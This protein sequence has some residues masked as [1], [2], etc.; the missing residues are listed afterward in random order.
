MKRSTDR[1]LTTH[2]SS[3]PRPDDLVELLQARNEDPSKDAAFRRRAAE[4]IGEVVDKQVEAGIDV[5]SDGEMGKP[6][7]VHYIRDR[8]SGFE[9]VNTQPSQ[10]DFDA[11]F[12]GYGKSLSEGAALATNQLW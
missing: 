2:T 8:V 11:E 4:A 7:F 5:I 10:L 12:P 6:S 9:G 1:I 3:L